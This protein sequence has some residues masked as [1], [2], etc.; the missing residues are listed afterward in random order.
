MSKNAFLWIIFVAQCALFTISTSA[1]ETEWGIGDDYYDDNR[2]EIGVTIANNIDTV[3]TEEEN[4]SEYYT[5]NDFDVLQKVQE[6]PKEE[7][8]ALRSSECGT[9]RSRILSLIERGAAD[10][11]QITEGALFNFVK[12]PEILD[13]IHV[14]KNI[15]V[16]GNLI[17]VLPAEIL[18]EIASRPGLFKE[19]SDDAIVA[20]AENDVA[21]AATDIGVLLEVANTRPHTIGEKSKKL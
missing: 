21:V 2:S 1:N 5:E 20:F 17:S 11:L 4:D 12:D 3:S 16:F 14:V 13:C 6:G 9:D 18:G 8:L 15:T 19:L 7:I 10:P